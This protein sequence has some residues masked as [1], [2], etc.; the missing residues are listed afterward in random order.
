MDTIVTNK[1]GRKPKSFIIPVLK[2]YN[3]SDTPIIAHLPI[4][5]TDIINESNDIFIK[6]DP[7]SFSSEKD[8]LGKKSVNK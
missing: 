6:M 1:R 5:Y 7:S 8:D 2:T 3:N 4:D